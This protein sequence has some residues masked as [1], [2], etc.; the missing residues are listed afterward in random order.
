MNQTNQIINFGFTKIGDWQL[1]FGGICFKFKI[2]SPQKNFIYSFVIDNQVVYIGK[3][4]QTIY[5]RMHGY[6]K[7]GP[8]QNTNIRINRL[9]YEN[10]INGKCVEIYFFQPNIK[11][12]YQGIDID[13]PAGLEISFIKYFKPCW[14]LLGK[15]C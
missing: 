3:S 11:L 2:K 6:Q 5:Q 10:L 15:N 8:T 9:I 4:T 12:D 7:P 13:L 1:I 14:N